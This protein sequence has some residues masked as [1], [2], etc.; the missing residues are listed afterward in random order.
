MWQFSQAVEGLSDGCLEL[1]IPVTGGNVSFYNQ[2]GDVP[3][4]PTPVVGV[5]GV[6]DDVARRIPSR[7]AGRGR[8][9]LPARRHRDRAR[10]LGVGRHRARPPRR[11]PAGRRPR[12]REAPRRA[13]AR[14]I[15]AV[16]RLERARPVRRRPRAGARRGRHALRRRRARLAHASSW[17]AT[18]WMPRPPCSPSRPA[19]SSCRCRARTT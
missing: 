14:G 1:G 2:T 10:R 17:S 12:R 13:A 5:L 7:L 16:A 6:I 11:P 9:H 15:A 19:A 3:I 8:E 4:F 18:A